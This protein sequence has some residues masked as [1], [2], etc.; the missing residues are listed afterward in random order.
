MKARRTISVLLAAAS[1]LLVQENTLAQ[2]QA[3]QQDRIYGSQLMTEQERN[4]YRARMR[5]AQT[6]QERE[7]LRREH[8]EQMKVRAQQRGVTLPDE[9]PPRGG[10]GYGAGVAG[11]GPGGM[12]PG[13]GMGGS[14]GR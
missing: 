8:H 6:E 11:K 2:T 7:R 12:G 9:P 13:A 10:P 14:R 3:R 5:S 4:E 1:L